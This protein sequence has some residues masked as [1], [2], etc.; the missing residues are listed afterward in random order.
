M[1]TEATL[2]LFFAIIVVPITKRLKLGSILGYLIAGVLL[3]PLF[4]LIHDN[5][6]SIQHF[7][8]FGVVMMMF[9]IGIELKPKKVWELR[10]SLIGLGGLQVIIS[11]VLL[12]FICIFIFNIS[13]NQALAIS[14]ILSLSSTAI[15]LQSLQEARQ[16]N[17]KAGQSILSVLISQD[18]IV[19]PIFAILPLLILKHTVVS[20]DRHHNNF[21]VSSPVI[22]AIIIFITILI[23]IIVSK[24]LLRH[25]FRYIA[26][27]KLPEIFTGLVLLIVISVSIFMNYLGLSPALGAFIAGVILSESEYRHE[28][29]SQISPFKGLLMGLF[30]ISIGASISF[31]ILVT[32]WEYVL[33]GVFLLMSSKMLV[34]MFI[35]KIYKFD[36]SNFWL[37]SLSLTQ[38]GEFAFVLLSF[39]L[40]IKLIPSNTVDIITLIVI[41]SMLLTPLLFMLY[42]KIIL[43]ICQNQNNRDADNIEHCSKVI[44]A[45]AGRFGQIIARVLK[46]ND[47]NP[48]I[49]DND[50]NTIETFRKYGNIAYYGDAL[51]P[52]LLISAGT[53]EAKVFV[54][55][56]D[57]RDGQIDLVSMIR[58][59]Q[60]EIIIIARAKDRHHV[61]EL[62]NAGANYTIRE[63]FESASSA[64]VETLVRLGEDK[65]IAKLKVDKFKAYDNESLEAAEEMWLKNGEDKD[66][67]NQA[68]INRN[69]LSELMKLESKS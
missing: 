5:V 24:L 53:R 58:R 62:K 16:S 48:V 21:I 1:L 28:I 66:Y 32:N 38:G 39:T 41:L 27:T 3:G 35:A 23:M 12:T 49:L 52:E 4:G 50:I 60:K 34:L 55:A 25:I 57:D 59:H 40:T 51:N 42:E 29:E 26:K 64:A 69:V 67:I 36:K 7:A 37:F 47:Y 10:Y 54:A 19:I 61:Y 6:E 2:F 13:W 63:T 65:R 15:V 17:T 18:I 31:H 22:H 30:F 43:P 56:I 11:T 20:I 9:L 45:G 33:L 44:I 14:L 46:A 68:T 8:E